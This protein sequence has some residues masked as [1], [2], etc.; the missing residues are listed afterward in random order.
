MDSANL[1]SGPSLHYMELFFLFTLWHK[2]ITYEKLFWNIYFPK[3]TN[4]TRNSAEKSF[5]PGDFE[6]ANSLENYEK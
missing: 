5:F 4:F 6:G 2:I 1:L 3:I